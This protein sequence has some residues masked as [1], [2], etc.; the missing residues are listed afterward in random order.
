[1]ISKVESFVQTAEQLRHFSD[2]FQKPTHGWHL[3]F[4]NLNQ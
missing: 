2:P 1:M 4:P 3:P